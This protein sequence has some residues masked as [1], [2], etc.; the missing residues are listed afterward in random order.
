MNS[1]TFCSSSGISAPIEKEHATVWLTLSAASTKPT[2]Q[3]FQSVNWDLADWG[4]ARL[5]LLYEA[6]RDIKN[7]AEQLADPELSIEEAAD[8]L[9]FELQIAQREALSGGAERTVK[10]KDDSCPWMNKSL[11]RTI[12]RKHQAYRQWKS[13]KTDASFARMKKTRISAN[14]QCKQAKS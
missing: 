1:L 13:N 2:P 11:L 3:A 4:K 14:F 10:L 5:S 12:Q 9:T 8:L 6:N 7:L